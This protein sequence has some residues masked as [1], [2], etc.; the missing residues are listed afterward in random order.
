MTAASA[1][2]FEAELRKT[3]PGEPYEMRG[4]RVYPRFV[5]DPPVKEDDDEVFEAPPA[6]PR[7]LGQVRVVE[8]MKFVDGQCVV[9]TVLPWMEATPYEKQNLDRLSKTSVSEP[10]R[11]HLIVVWKDKRRTI[12][13][14]S[15]E[16][17]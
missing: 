13:G 2:N 1:K 17:V 3:C 16:R 14:R 6:K 5:I 11:S 9:G 10:G 7:V 12:S 15:V 8:D 4:D